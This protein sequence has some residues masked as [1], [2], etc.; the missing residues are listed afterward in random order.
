MSSYIKFAATVSFLEFI[1]DEFY[2]PH[3]N[4]D[5]FKKELDVLKKP[6]SVEYLVVNLKDHPKIFDIAEEFFQLKRFTNTQ[7]THFLFDVT[8]LNLQDLD[9]LMRYVDIGISHYEDGS[10]NDVFIK[11]FNQINNENLPY[12]KAMAAKRA[13]VEYVSYILKKKNRN[14][15]YQHIRQSLGA[16]YRIANYLVENLNA[17]KQFPAT[18]LKTYLSLKRIPRDTKN[19]HGKFGVLKIKEILLKL[20]IVDVDRISRDK[21]ISLSGVKEQRIKDIKYS[22]ITER[23]I[24]YVAK[25]NSMKLKKFDFIIFKKGIPTYCIETNFYSTTGSK[26]G[27]NMGEYTDLLE[28]IGKIN[29]EKQTS[30]KFIWITDGNHWLTLEGE[31]DYR[32]LKE[33]FFK[34]NWQLVNYNLFA[35]EIS[36][37]LK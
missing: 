19:I 16:R 2:K 4:I 7:Y 10:E 3:L 11:L 15:L 31:K 32:N 8:K 34:E 18:D 35:Q 13:V 6:I 21:V 28:D 1:Q 30:L 37:L 27:I 23:A 25:R 20:N 12:H 36:N 9:K 14:Q 29:K 24:E 5:D 26:I 33:N 22:Y 17:D